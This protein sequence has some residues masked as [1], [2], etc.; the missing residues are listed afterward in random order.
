MQVKNVMTE[1]CEFIKP[2]ATLQEAAQRMRDLDC[3]F[4][5]IGP[6]ENNKLEGVITDRDIVIRCISEGMDPSTTTVKE[7]ETRRVLYCYQTD[8]LEAATRSMRDQQVYRLIVLDSPESKQL[9]GVVSWGD[10]V[11]HHE[12]QLAINAAEGIKAVA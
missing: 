1:N 3:G 5:A 9:C 4:L 2:D 10:I 12:D 11:R 8:D 7:A 6:E